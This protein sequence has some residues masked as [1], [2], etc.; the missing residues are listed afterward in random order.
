MKP[1]SAPVPLPF[2]TDD[3]IEAA[4]LACRYRGLNSDR[5]PL[6]E[7]PD[8]VRAAFAWLDAQRAVQR[9]PRLY[10]PVK[11]YVEGWAQRYVST[12][13]VI[14]AAFLH[15]RIKGTYPNFNLSAWLTLP[16]A[17]RLS[18]LDVGIHGYTTHPEVYHYRETIR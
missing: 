7:H 6:H 16:D 2:P 18:G 11:A 10:R 14:V 4:K 17:H 1:T 12:D 9:N 15:P 8:C 13:D 3:E 5:S